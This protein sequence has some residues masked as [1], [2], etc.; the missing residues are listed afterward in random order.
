LD[1]EEKIKPNK[2]IENKIQHNATITVSYLLWIYVNDYSW[3]KVLKNKYTFN[4]PN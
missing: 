4:N 2:E 1:K 3:T